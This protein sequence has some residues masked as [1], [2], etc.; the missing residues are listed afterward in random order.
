MIL[1]QSPYGSAKTCSG[2]SRGKVLLRKYHIRYS[3]AMNE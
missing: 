3:A 2:F 1:L